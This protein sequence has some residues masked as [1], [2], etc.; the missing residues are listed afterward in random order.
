MAR[1]P[2]RRPPPPFG[3]DDRTYAQLWFYA[4]PVLGFALGVAV[5]ATLVSVLPGAWWGRFVSVVAG[6]L[7]GTVAVRAGQALHRR[8]GLEDRKSD[9]ERD[10]DR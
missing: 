5:F 4:L 6:L 2:P 3:L 8:L 10:D 7:V 9:D 1:K